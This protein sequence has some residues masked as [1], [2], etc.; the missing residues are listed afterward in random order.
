MIPPSP[1]LSA[2][3]T[4]QTYLI[5]TTTITAQNTSDRRP[6]TASFPA[7]PDDL[8]HS[9]KVETFAEGIDRARSDIAENDAERADDNG[10]PQRVRPAG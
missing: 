6:K 4:R 3:M 2:R 8:R 9:R 10:S 5:V 7:L 1:S